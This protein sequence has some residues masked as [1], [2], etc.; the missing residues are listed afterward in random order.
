MSMIKLNNKTVVIS[1]L[2]NSRKKGLITS[3]PK[4]KIS[5]LNTKEVDIAMIDAD[6]Y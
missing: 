5:I 6:I 3:T 4:I 1:T 2:D